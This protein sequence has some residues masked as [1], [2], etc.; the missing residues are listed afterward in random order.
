MCS[1]LAPPLLGV[2]SPRILGSERVIGLRLSTCLSCSGEN[3][4]LGMSRRMLVRVLVLC[5][6]T[7]ILEELNLGAMDKRIH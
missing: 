3:W 4:T 7:T 1:S 5:E 6:G 2:G